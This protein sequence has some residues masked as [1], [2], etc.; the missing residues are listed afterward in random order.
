MSSHMKTSLW[1]PRK[2]SFFEPKSVVNVHRISRKVDGIFAPLTIL[3]LTIDKP[4]LPDCIICGF[5]NLQVWK[6]VPNPLCCFESHR[7][8]H[9]QE[10]CMSQ[11]ICVYCGQK[12]HCPP[13]QSSPHCIDCDDPHG[14]NSRDCPKF[15]MEREIQKIR[16]TD[17]VS[18]LKARHHYQAQLPVNYSWSSVSVLKSSSSTSS[19]S[20]TTQPTQ[21]SVHC[22]VSLFKLLNDKDKS[23]QLLRILTPIVK[24]TAEPQGAERSSS[25]ALSSKDLTPSTSTS[26]SEGSPRR[27]TSPSA[28]PSCQESQS[29]F[30]N[31]APAGDFPPSDPDNSLSIDV[32]SSQ[33]LG[34]RK[35]HRSHKRW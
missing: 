11:A 28:K 17:K 27:T 10:H 14:S 31:T 7:F 6:Y 20:Q 23:P 4:S 9:T 25:S 34:R 16:V 32:C 1:N 15:R 29:P 30:G 13:C 24:P 19:S 22:Q 3:I 21:H 12:A 26:S 18:F 35:P 33:V 2:K 5:F 8:G